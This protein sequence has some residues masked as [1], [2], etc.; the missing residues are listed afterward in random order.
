ML[1]GLIDT[2]LH[3]GQESKWPRICTLIGLSFKIMG[4]TLKRKKKYYNKKYLGKD[5]VFVRPF[6]TWF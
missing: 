1:V 2:R 6:Y 5:L 3:F 4:S